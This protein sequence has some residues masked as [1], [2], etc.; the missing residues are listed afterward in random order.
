MATS[1]ASSKQSNNT[2][3]RRN[4]ASTQGL[5]F[6]T[7]ILLFVIG[8]WIGVKLYVGSLETK[9]QTLVENI[10]KERSNYDPVQVSETIDFYE[11][12][13]ILDQVNKKHNGVM[14]KLLSDLEKVMVP[15]VVLSSLEMERMVDG[16][17]IVHIEGDAEEFDILAQQELAMRDSGYFT[18]IKMGDTSID[19]VGRKTFM[20]EATYVGSS[21]QE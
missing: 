4:R 11:R 21:L 16:E 10:E 14:V 12:L 8:V 9:N 17:N 1:F 6:A 2:H 7:L 20:L 19:D 5:V 3:R 15:R 18:N 13:D